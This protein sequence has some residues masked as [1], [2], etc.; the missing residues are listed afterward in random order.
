MAFGVDR[1][2][3]EVRQLTQKVDALAGEF[4]HLC[5]EVKTGFACLERIE[6]HVVSQIEEMDAKLDNIA[7]T[8]TKLGQD[9][10]TVVDALKAIPNPPQDLTAQLA[11][12][13]AIAQTL[14][15]TDA[16]TLSNL[17]PT[18][19]PPPQSRRR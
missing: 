11:K 6:R 3:H 18:P 12:L 13:D 10:Q 16:Q 8:E 5:Q 17:P 19:E 9:I 15:D 14:V 2:T 1:L 4:G 7:N